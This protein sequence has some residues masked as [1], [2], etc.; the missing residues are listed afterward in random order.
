MVGR[1]Q[2]RLKVRYGGAGYMSRRL[3]EK[4]EEQERRQGVRKEDRWDGVRRAVR[5]RVHACMGDMASGNALAT[6]S[7]PWSIFLQNCNPVQRGSSKS[8]ISHQGPI[9][10]ESI[11]TNAWWVF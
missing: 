5:S 1:V 2:Q 9:S 6:R 7:V 11:I 3:V 8:G 4:T 10:F